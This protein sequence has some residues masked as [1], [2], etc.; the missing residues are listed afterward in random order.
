MKN[1]LRTI[2]FIL[3][4]TLSNISVGQTVKEVFGFPG[5]TP[6]P[7]TVTP[8]QGRNGRLYGTTTGIGRN[9]T[10]GTVFSLSP[11]GKGGT[12]YTFNGTDGSHPQSGLTLAT[13][14]N[15][16]GGATSGGAANFGVLFR[17]NAGGSYSALYQF[18]GGSDGANPLAPPIQASDGNLYGATDGDT[19]TAGAFYKLVP[20]SSTFATILT[21]NPDGS[22]GSIVSPPLMQASDGSLYA[23]AE[24]GGAN[25]CGTILNLSTSG[26]LIRLYSFLCGASGNFPAASLVEASDGTLYGT[27]VAGGNVTN[28]ECAN[29]C[30]IV[31]KMSQGLLTVMHSFSGYPTDGAFPSGGLTLG[32]DGNLYGAT[33]K[34]GAN[35]FGTLYQI[36]TG[37]QYKVL[38]SF[39][40]KIGSGPNATL[41]QHTNGSFY[42][43]AESGGQYDAGA[44]Y[45]LN[46]GL[47]PFIA[48][49]RSTG[50]IGQ[51]VQILGQGLTGSSGVTINGISS[52]SFKV[53][54]D[55]YMTA[56]IPANATT[57]P[58]LVTTPT[59]TLTSNHN[60]RIL[61]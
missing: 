34:G 6:A 57:G 21:L 27:T 31:F 12:I 22:Q 2:L 43:V 53:V 51:P 54:S 49:V 17:I 59:G 3:L 38:Y 16:Y 25:G 61:Q 8:A 20:S 30:G 11:V 4:P 35:D 1:L 19:V 5:S 55:T 26:K 39:V 41:L 36:T 45:S 42:G 47:A 33:G 56:I 28:G 24:T 44:V 23:T 7:G 46:M 58:V 48:L 14:G 37:G 9:V 18:S 10:N 52:T 32:T 13:D 29:G 15:F 50:R 40:D 60:L